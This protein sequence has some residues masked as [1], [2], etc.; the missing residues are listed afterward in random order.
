M[1]P[2]VLIVEDNEIL[3]ELMC[4]ALAEHNQIALVATSPREGLDLIE[5]HPGLGIVL[6]D[7]RL[8]QEMDG[9]SLI[10]QVLSARPQTHCIL[11]TGLPPALTPELPPEVELL[12]KPFALAKLLE[13][14]ATR[15]DAG[16]V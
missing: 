16:L 7:L 4:E 15:K 11:M 1:A 12:Q 10:K 5:R 13:M 8:K 2:S 9:L 14:V 3:G 6:V